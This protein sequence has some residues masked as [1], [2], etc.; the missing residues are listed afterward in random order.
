[1][2]CPDTD[3]VSYRLVVDG[4]VQPGNI[5]LAAEVNVVH[6]LAALGIEDSERPIS[7][8]SDEL[9]SIC[10]RE[11]CV[12][13]NAKRREQWCAVLFFV[14]LLARTIVESTCSNVVGVRVVAVHYAATFNVNQTN[15]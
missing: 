4:H 13:Q 14:R 8:R 6:L 7:A 12:C 3:P 1:M 10:K 11:A 2:H 15:L 5:C 9:E